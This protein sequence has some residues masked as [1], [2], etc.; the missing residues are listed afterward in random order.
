MELYA[1]KDLTFRGHLL[2]SLGER[3][4]GGV[5]AIPS[6]EDPTGSMH[7]Y[8]G[9]NNV[10]APSILKMYHSRLLTVL[11]R[12]LRYRF[13]RLVSSVALDQYHASLTSGDP[14]R[15]VDDQ[16]DEA[17][18]EQDLRPT[19]SARRVK[20]LIEQVTGQKVSPHTKLCAKVLT[21]VGCR[22]LFCPP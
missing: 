7:G 3:M 19:N 4:N 14:W 11:R 5:S 16:G 2:R 9:R 15:M 18:R 1:R 13:G 22:S 6:S 8:R 10:R 12:D 21:R 17:A 20:T